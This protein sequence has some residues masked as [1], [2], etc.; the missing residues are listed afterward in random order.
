MRKSKKSLRRL[1]M[2]SNRIFFDSNVL[3]YHL[4]GKEKARDLIEKV[5]NDEIIGFINP[6]VISE[7]L[8]FYIRANTKKKPY[9]IKK[10]P[11]ILKSLDF[12]NVFELFSIFR[13][14]DL[15]GEIVKISKEIIKNY[16]LLP[17]DDFEK[18]D[19]LEIIK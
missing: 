5:E 15:N 6:I 14:L 17:N 7:V 12:D 10:K 8:F 19:F 16:G 11:E 4:C 3:I 1:R 18:V 2:E 9:D 13:I